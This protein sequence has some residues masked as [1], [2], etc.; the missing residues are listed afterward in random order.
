MLTA[1]CG[2]AMFL[3]NNHDVIQLGHD[4]IYKLNRY[5]AYILVYTVHYLFIVV[6]LLFPKFISMYVL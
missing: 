4:F 1:D 2:N 6:L 5:I 3:Q